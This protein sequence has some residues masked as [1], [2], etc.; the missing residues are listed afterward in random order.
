[1]VLGLSGAEFSGETTAVGLLLLLALLPCWYSRTREPPVWWFHWI[2]THIKRSAPL[3]WISTHIK[4]NI[5]F[6]HTLNDLPPWDAPFLADVPGHSGDSQG[7]AARPS[8]P[9][10][11]SAAAAPPPGRLDWEGRARAAA[12][13]RGGR[14]ALL[15]PP[16]PLQYP[17]AFADSRAVAA[18]SPTPMMSGGGGSDPFPGQSAGL[19]SDYP[20]PGSGGIGGSA[21]PPHLRHAS[22]SSGS[23]RSGGGGTSLTDPSPGRR[24]GEP[25][26]HSASVPLP[27][28]SEGTST[29]AASRIPTPSRMYQQQQ[30]QPGGGGGNWS[31]PAAS[32]LLQG[33]QSVAPQPAGQ[34]VLYS[35][36]PR[37]QSGSFGSSGRRSG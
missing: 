24:S 16:P 35:M 12:S 20:Q 31:L 19:F 26:S 23:L 2:S 7:W 32:A 30:Q 28:S 10:T 17:T 18:A 6:L 5:G 8:S 3:G 22:R 29:A 36:A 21:L 34:A 13:A 37:R 11:R 14:A 1:M 4:R 33:G 15:Q 27:D 9:P 25:P